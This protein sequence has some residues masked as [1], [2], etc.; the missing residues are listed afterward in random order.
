MGNGEAILLK[1]IWPIETP[2]YYKVHFGRWN[3]VVQ[4]LDEWVRD[5]SLWVM[6]QRSRPRTNAFNRPYIFSLMDF[7]HEKDV[8]L[9][10]GVFRVLSRHQD[11]YDVELTELGRPFIG[12]L[13]LRSSYRSR[14]TRVNF[15]NHYDGPHTLRVSEILREPFSGRTFPGYEEVTVSFV[16]LETLL[17]NNR[18]DWKAALESV[19]GVYLI[20]DAKS[21]KQYVGAAYGDQGVWSR[22]EDY[23]NSGHGGNA[24]IRDWLRDRGLDYCRANFRFALLEYHRSHTPDETIRTREA[25]WKGVLLSREFG[26]NRN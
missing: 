26:L 7:Y 6:W 8:W 22:W 25:W 15:E 21:G 10:G 20:T 16:E 24:D 14:A 5:R 3:G 13:K 2:R 17:R 12:R 1:D 19:K 18:P 9:F 23:V 11:R 4:P